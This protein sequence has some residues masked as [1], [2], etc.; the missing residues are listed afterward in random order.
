M[1]SFRPICPYERLPVDRG[2]AALVEGSQVAL[3]RTHDGALHAVS[4]LDP[5]SGAMVLARGIL[6][7]RGARVTVTSPVYKQAFDLTSGECLEDPA[8]RLDVHPVR[9]RDGVVE[10]AL[11]AATASD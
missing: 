1:R 4:N 10:V 6:G 3:F 9:V 7:S 2:V 8:V 11:P 5:F